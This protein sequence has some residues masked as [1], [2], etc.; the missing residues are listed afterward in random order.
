MMRH[1]KRI[2]WADPYFIKIH[3][4]IFKLFLDKEPSSWMMK[5]LH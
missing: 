1:A 2:A 4:L 3:L 5:M